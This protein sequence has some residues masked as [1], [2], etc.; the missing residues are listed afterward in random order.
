MA[1]AGLWGLGGGLGRR[2]A[3]VRFRSP[4]RN[5]REMC[6]VYARLG[7]QITTRVV[8]RDRAR[9]S[10]VRVVLLPLPPYLPRTRTYLPV[11]VGE[12]AWKEL[13]ATDRVSEV[14]CTARYFFAAFLLLSR[15][16]CALRE[17]FLRFLID[18][19]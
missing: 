4:N 3:H 8:H 5:E 7:T 18:L 14:P 17:L 12:R 10:T 6:F 19:P 1:I 2:A 16:T 15:R 11:H 9:Y 13:L